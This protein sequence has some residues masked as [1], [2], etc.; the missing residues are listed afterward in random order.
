MKRE[1]VII[2]VIII[3]LIFVYFYK[4]RI[5]GWFTITSCVFE[6]MDYLE[7]KF[8]PPYSK[9]VQLI[10]NDK[11][12][13]I[14]PY[15]ITKP[16]AWPEYGGKYLVL[17]TDNNIVYNIV[18]SIDYKIIDDDAICAK[19]AEGWNTTANLVIGD[20][21]SIG[22]RWR[23]VTYVCNMYQSKVN[24]CGKTPVFAFM[25]SSFPDW[26]STNSA[27]TQ[28]ITPVEGI[29]PRIS[30]VLTNVMYNELVIDA[31]TPGSVPTAITSDG[32]IIPDD[33][34]PIYFRKFYFGL[35]TLLSAGSRYILIPTKREME[36]YIYI[37]PITS[38][39]MVKQLI[40]VDALKYKETEIH[41]TD[42]DKARWTLKLNND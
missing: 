1:H 24:K 3:M 11:Y 33:G 7:A 25:P 22:S 35:Q 16:H 15:G 21:G 36:F 28:L 39:K 10:T 31:L 4:N 27:M 17:I 29:F 13:L 37:L 41:D 32:S 26:V 30:G 12:T 23:M 14:V 2:A 34:N 18:T 40:A 5:K 42:T 9:P 19:K 8:P 6:N 20:V 38:N